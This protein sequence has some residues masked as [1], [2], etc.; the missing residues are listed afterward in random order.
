MSLSNK[1]ASYPS[2]TP[3]KGRLK[4]Q[5]KLKQWWP[6]IL[7]IS[8]KRTA[9]SNLKPLNIKM[10][11]KY[12]VENPGHNHVLGFL[13]SLPEYPSPRR[14]KSKSKSK[15]KNL[16]V[17]GFKRRQEK[18]TNVPKYDIPP[19]KKTKK[20]KH[21]SSFQTQC[22]LFNV[23]KPIHKQFKFMTLSTV[24]VSQARNSRN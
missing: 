3:S 6:T 19:P 20:Q 2:T 9:A 16:E 14:S 11:R 7:L 1:A 21:L 15:S 18:E 5:R 13:F 12:D 8:A 10:T 4:M 24:S 17:K 23:R 22:Y